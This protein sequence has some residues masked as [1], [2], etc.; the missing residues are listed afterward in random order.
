M[1]VANAITG[2]HKYSLVIASNAQWPEIQP[3]VSR[4]QIVSADLLL[5]TRTLTDNCNLSI[6][7]GARQSEPT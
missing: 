4:R 2:I 1:P 3:L 5:L 7:I 6:M